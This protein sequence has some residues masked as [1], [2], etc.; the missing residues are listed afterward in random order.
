MQVEKYR[1]DISNQLSKH[2]KVDQV[3][4]SIVPASQ[5]NGPL[6][7]SMIVYCY[8]FFINGCERY[9]TFAIE[10]DG[11]V[12]FTRPKEGIREFLTPLIR[13]K[14]FMFMCTGDVYNR[15]D[16]IGKFIESKINQISRDVME[17]AFRGV[18]SDNLGYDDTAFTYSFGFKVTRHHKEVLSF[19]SEVEL[20]VRRNTLAVSYESYR[21]Q[22]VN[23]SLGQFKTKS[24]D[25]VS[26][27][28][29]A[30]G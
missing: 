7:K 18:F 24:G 15:K 25:A 5:L 21:G 13:N 20:I 27:E 14:D 23:G 22:F 28:E 2:F 17:N 26:M 8:E 4:A 3:K 19:D 12:Y 29:I 30:R 9:F 11:E 6:L 10:L 1:S 16:V